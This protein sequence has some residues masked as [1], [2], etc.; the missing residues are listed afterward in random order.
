MWFGAPMVLLDGRDGAQ[1]MA[2]MLR[3]RLIETL[4]VGPEDPDWIRHLEWMWS[5]C[6]DGYLARRVLAL[7]PNVRP[8][9]NR[10]AVREPLAAELSALVKPT[11]V[12]FAV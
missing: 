11:D 4:V 3:A 9:R 6:A 5:V 2:G 10:R 1:V 12:F 8:S 7:T